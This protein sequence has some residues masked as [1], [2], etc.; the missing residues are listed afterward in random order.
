MVRSKRSIHAL[1]GANLHAQRGEVF[2]LLGPNGAG[3]TTLVKILLGVI[4]STSGTALLFDSPAGS[5]RARSRVGYLPESLRIDRHHT[6]R[7]ALYFYGRMSGMSNAA[8]RGKLDELL[9]SVGLQGRDRESVRRYSKGMYQRL[10][11][12]QA[13]LHDPDLLILDEPT[14]GLDPVGRNE[15][16]RILLELKSRGKTI[17]LNSHILQ[18]VEMV[19]DRVAIMSKGLV[20][21]CGTIDEL[22]RNRQAAKHV[23]LELVDHRSGS[24]NELLST[25][26]AIAQELQNQWRQDLKDM[27]TVVPSSAQTV[28]LQALCPD[29]AAI[30]WLVDLVR[31]RN[32]S[33][34]SLQSHRRSLEDVFLEL[35]GT[36]PDR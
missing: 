28:S 32:L 24:Q 11:L 29:Q 34:V 30:D 14:D 8:I 1:R 5:A 9:L 18:E 15:V 7:S 22:T 3:K 12:A 21:A 23:T 25:A 17:F 2:G 31:Q 27:P 33:I 26:Q 36:E 13:L 35:V 4:R 16:R 10:G 20:R 6:A 19:C